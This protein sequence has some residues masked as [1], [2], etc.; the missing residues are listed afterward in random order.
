MK[1]QK[2]QSKKK[3][4]ANPKARAE[5]CSSALLDA[6]DE[7]IVKRIIIKLR[8]YAAFMELAGCTA[9]DVDANA[10]AKEA[11]EELHREGIKGQRATE[12]MLAVSER[13]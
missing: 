7:N 1:N 8:L 3:T 5:L 10:I 4:S 12:I 11:Q 13:I 6:R 2:P 9:K